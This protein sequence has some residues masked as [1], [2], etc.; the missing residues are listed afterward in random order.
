MILSYRVYEVR[1]VSCYCKAMLI[2]GVSI[3]VWLYQ[4]RMGRLDRRMTDDVE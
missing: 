1:S 2:G 4:N 3:F